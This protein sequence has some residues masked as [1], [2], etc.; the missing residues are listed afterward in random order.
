MWSDH[1]TNFV[2]ANCILKALLEFLHSQKTNQVISNFCSSQGITWQFIP[3][4][5][6]HF[7]G[8]WEAAVKSLKTHMS[9]VVGNAKLNFEELTTVLSQIEACLNSRPLGTMPHNDDDG[10]ELLTPGHF[11]IG[12][13]MQAL[14][15]HALSYKP[16]PMLRRW[17]LCEALVRH[18]WNRWSSEYVTNLRK[19][20]KWKQ[21]SKNLHKGDVVVLREDGM[22]PTQWPIA[23]I[24]ETHQG[25][26]GLVRVVTLKTK[27]GVYTRPATKVALLLSC[28]EHD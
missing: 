12:R 20:S 17:Y 21:L 25:K 2:G 28:E 19:Y 1:S 10:I 26:D 3:E 18:F 24:V 16:M 11:I 6:P 14:P 7:G 15:D 22:V 4:R 27:N 8:L 5:A 9:R 13:P 23:R